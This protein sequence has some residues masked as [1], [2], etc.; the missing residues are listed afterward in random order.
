MKKDG[1]LYF[2]IDYDVYYN[3]VLE[4]VKILDNYEVIYYIFD[5]YNLEKVENNIKI[6]FE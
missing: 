1:M 4:L 6:E 3:D 2:K 5:L